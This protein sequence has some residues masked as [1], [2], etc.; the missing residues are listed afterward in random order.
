MSNQNQQEK[1]QYFVAISDDG[2]IESSKEEMLQIIE[3][4]R[5]EISYLK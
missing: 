2:D 3:A 5:S 1:P 4:M